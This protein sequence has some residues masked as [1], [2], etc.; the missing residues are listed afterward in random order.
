MLRTY[1]P[2]V[3]LAPGPDGGQPRDRL[4]G[5][6][7]GGSAAALIPYPHEEIVIGRV[8]DRRVPR[9]AMSGSRA[10]G[11]DHLAA[12]LHDVDLR[13]P[14]ARLRG[15]GVADRDGKMEDVRPVE[16]GT[17]D[18]AVDAVAALDVPVERGIGAPVL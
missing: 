15:V 10:V 4:V 2:P 14:V 1:P 11:F 18:R 3:P 17:H 9:H 7:T 6:P 12:V 8:L 16:R 13:D 5:I